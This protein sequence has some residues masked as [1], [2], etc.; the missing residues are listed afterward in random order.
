[1]SPTAGL[2]S[3]WRNPDAPFPA[4]LARSRRLRTVTYNPRGDFQLPRTGQ[5]ARRT[6]HGKPLPPRAPLHRHGVSAARPPI[7]GFKPNAA[8]PVLSDRACA[9]T[10]RI[11]RIFSHLSHRHVSGWL[12]GGPPR[13][14]S[15]RNVPQQPLP[16]NA[17]RSRVVFLCHGGFRVFDSASLEVGRNVFYSASV[18]TPL[19]LSTVPSLAGALVEFGAEGWNES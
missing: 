7:E 17:I 11:F 15:S 10:F 1:M 18:R 12:A 8:D 9:R 6:A 13:K 2:L 19:S 5:S 4:R 3:C 14:P 16:P